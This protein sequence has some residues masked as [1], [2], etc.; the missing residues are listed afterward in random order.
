MRK[1]L[2]FA[3]A[4]AVLSMSMIGGA[5]AGSVTST[6]ETVGQPRVELASPPVSPN[7]TEKRAVSNRPQDYS[8]RPATKQRVMSFG[9]DWQ[10]WGWRLF[11]RFF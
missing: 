2:L 5:K 3:F 8:S 10:S 6:S 11:E 7:E 9:R 4:A 1:R